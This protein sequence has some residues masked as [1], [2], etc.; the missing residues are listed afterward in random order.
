ML[1]FKITT[2]QG[3][4]LLELMMAVAIIGILAAIAFPNY[5]SYILHSNRTEGMALLNDAAARQERYFAQN[6]HYITSQ[7]DIAKL[8]M[9]YTSGTTTTSP[10]GK[11]SLTL[12]KVDQDGG[13]TLTAT[14][15]DTQTRDDE[16]NK[17]GKL[18]LTANGKQGAVR[19]AGGTSADNCW[20]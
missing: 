4:T 6:N 19:L 3:F 5:Q 13:Y 7:S 11:Y 2:A 14:P 20:R 9:P 1:R 8:N 10:A 12:S 18:T 17:C 15:L 16:V